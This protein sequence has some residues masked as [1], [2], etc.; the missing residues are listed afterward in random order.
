MTAQKRPASKSRVVFSV[1][2]AIEEY[3][4]EAKRQEALKKK[5]KSAGSVQKTIDE[6]CGELA[7]R[8]GV[9][10]EYI[11]AAI[12]DACELTG[13][14]RDT[15]FASSEDR[16]QQLVS[17]TTWIISVKEQLEQA[18]KIAE[19]F[20]RRLQDVENR[21]AAIGQRSEAIQAQADRLDDA[22]TVIG[23]RSS[24]MGEKFNAHLFWCDKT[25]RD[26][27]ARL[28]LIEDPESKGE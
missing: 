2:T 13:Y 5:G 25:I 22:M 16:L 23:P 20:D 3:V 28:R 6:F 27:H 12:D 18:I 4:N 1:A 8:G 24:E 14:S 17:T 7:D 15:I 10:K 19:R 9:S 11:E 26:I 21:L